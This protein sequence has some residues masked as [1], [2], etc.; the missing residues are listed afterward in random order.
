VLGVRQIATSP[1]QLP[2]QRLEVNGR[3][4]GPGRDTAL[5]Q[6]LDQAVPVNSVVETDDVHKPA[7]ARR[8]IGNVRFVHTG[9]LVD[10]LV[11]PL[12][13]LRPLSQDFLDPL[14]LDQAKRRTHF[15]HTIIVP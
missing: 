10:A 2:V 7:H 4:I 11:V 1:P 12:R 14:K 3:E 5:V 9:D 15:I 8:R 6:E 13:D